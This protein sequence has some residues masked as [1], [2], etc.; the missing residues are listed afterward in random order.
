MDVIVNDRF[1][2]S[3]DRGWIDFYNKHGWVVIKNNLNSQIIKSTIIDWENLKKDCAKE[4]GIPVNEYELEISQWRDLWTNG[5]TFKELIFSPYLHSIAQ[6]GMGWNGSRLL[7]DHLICKPFQ[8]SNKKIPWHQDSM[9]WPVDIPGCSTWTALENVSLEDGCL[10]VIDK[11][12]LEGCEEPIDFMAKEREDFPD[13]S[14]KVSLPVNKGSTI[15]LHSLTWHRSSINQGLHDR[16]AHIGLWI[17]PDSKWRPDLVDWHP[18]NQHV[19][20]EPMARLEG[21]KFPHF[22]NIDVLES[23]DEDIHQGTTRY[24]DIS[25]FDASKIVSKQLAE[26]SGGSGGILEILGDENFVSIISQKTIEN[27][28]CIDD[29]EIKKSLERLRISYLAYELHKARNVYNDAYAN[30]W[31]VAGNAWNE[32]LTV[33]K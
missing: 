28:F 27:K 8:G 31:D 24:N 16:P 17:H 3:D 19:E 9:F 4:M 6:D 2:Q 23:P 15:L 14:I 1:F 10:E 22:G 29:D 7:H 32:L 5:G 20:S 30:W 21:S 18:I 11:S 33:D 26:I 12:H 13:G 25:M